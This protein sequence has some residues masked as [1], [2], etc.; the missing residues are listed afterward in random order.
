MIKGIG[1]ISRFNNIPLAVVKAPLYIAA[2]CGFIFFT[3][4]GMLPGYLMQVSDGS[5]SVYPD[6][7]WI[8]EELISG[9]YPS[10]FPFNYGG[11]PFPCYGGGV[12][13]LCVIPF[14]FFPPDTAATIM[15]LGQMTVL[16][17][18]LFVWLRMFAFSEA[19]SFLVTGLIIWSGPTM[20]WY[21][22][23]Y[24]YSAYVYTVIC[25]I[26][27][28]K[29]HRC[30]NIWYLFF[31]SCAVALSASS[32]SIQHQLN[33]P[34][35]IL[36]VALTWFVNNRQ[37]RPLLLT[38]LFLG[39]GYCMA[40]IHILPVFHSLSNVGRGNYNYGETFHFH[41][42][43]LFLAIWSG[44]EPTIKYPAIY[45]FLCPLLLVGFIMFFTRRCCKK[46]EQTFVITGFA[47]FVLI[48][49]QMYIVPL[50][51]PA[52]RIA[53]PYRQWFVL[54]LV[55][56]VA[57]A[58]AIDTLWKDI[59]NYGARPW[60]YWI[61]S[62][63]VVSF[64]GIFQGLEVYRNLNLLSANR[65]IA[66]FLFPVAVL[67]FLFLIKNIWIRSIIAIA[68]F[69]Y[70]YYFIGNQIRTLYLKTHVQNSSGYKELLKR[71]AA[72]NK[73]INPSAVF[74]VYRQRYW[75]PFDKTGPL[76]PSI[77]SLYG[78]RSIAG[79]VGFLFLPE[80]IR[81]SYYKDR[82]ISE[83]DFWSVVYP[84][85]ISMD[86][87]ILA[88]YGV[89]IM[90]VDNYESDI[91][92]F[93]L[94]SS[95]LKCANL[96]NPR[97]GQN[98]SD[99]ISWNLENMGEYRYYILSI[100]V[101]FLS[102]AELN[103]FASDR[104]I[105]SSKIRIFADS[106]LDNNLPINLIDGDPKTFWHISM[107]DASKRHYL[108]IDFGCK[109]S[110]SRIAALKR[111]SY[112]DQFWENAFLF[113]VPDEFII[114]KQDG[115]LSVNDKITLNNWLKSPHTVYGVSN[116]DSPYIL[117]LNKKYVGRAYV[118]NDDGSLRGLPI[119]VDTPKYISID[120]RGL[121]KGTRVV[122]ADNYFQGWRVTVD[123][124]SVK[125]DAFGHFRSVT[126]PKEASVVE[127]SYSSK[128]VRIGTAI[129]IFSMLTAITISCL[130]FKVEK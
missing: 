39:L 3:H 80:S 47:V 35:A 78:L 67:P 129:S 83:N 55:L 92:G 50:V 46:Y 24:P 82:I 34:I 94:N 101:N 25:M 15:N 105:P 128:Y 107:D 7:H 1:L 69:G 20:F 71:Y 70:S 8:A 108:L 109:T 38:L 63:V 40:S 4:W 18:A 11:Y 6:L 68:L 77:S 89:E 90:V 51:M 76:E 111:Q 48:I 116:N 112:G 14:F 74:S 86:A 117:L 36:V 106:T 10:W 91:C 57:C 120:V 60:T 114:E 73:S 45:F 31:T 115:K 28:K 19:S 75:G 13:D 87:E 99:C 125:P 121:P 122:L 81:T 126:L 29:Y 100:D 102:C 113:A 93:I 98:V 41:P 61:G 127:W 66:F 65:A 27:V 17:I 95:R 23:G 88:R 110:I 56:G 9:N 119:I 104:M 33:V 58:S 97:D 64:F 26:L 85:I 96:N 123:G 103:F 2:L 53:D 49:A 16:F 79:P 84:E 12:I 21:G 30:N 5:R 44:Q 22:Y 54:L 62:I 52:Y 32:M 72:L 37:I 42:V 124:V 43:K 59:I 130:T 118:Q